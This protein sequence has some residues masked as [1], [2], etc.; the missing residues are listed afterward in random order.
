MLFFLRLFRLSVLVCHSSGLLNHDDPGTLSLDDVLDSLNENDQVPELTITIGDLK[1]VILALQKDFERSFRSQQNRIRYL[2]KKVAYQENLINVLE[3]DESLSGRQR[4][5]KKKPNKKTSQQLP[6]H[7]KSDVVEA[8]NL[9]G[10]YS[11]DIKEVQKESW[12]KEMAG[13]PQRKRKG[14][15]QFMIRNLLF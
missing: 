8:F 13:R 4:Q 15:Q 1:M 11:L 6:I 14:S 10:Y 3:N 5:Q 12:R 9:T 2:E 7:N